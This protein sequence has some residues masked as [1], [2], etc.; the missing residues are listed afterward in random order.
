VS[1]RTERATL[2]ARARGRRT[3]HIGAGIDLR[4]RIG[5]RARPCHHP[6][7]WP[8]FVRRQMGDDATKLGWIDAGHGGPPE[9]PAASGHTTLARKN[10]A[11]TK[12]VF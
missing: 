12:T 9:M 10:K 1:G 4:H 3:A 2:A 8:Q 6:F 7:Q 11:G 5:P